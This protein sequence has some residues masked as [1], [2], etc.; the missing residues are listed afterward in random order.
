MEKQALRQFLRNQSQAQIPVTL[1]AI[2][3][4]HQQIREKDKRRVGIIA[5]C[6]EL[7]PAN[8]ENNNCSSQVV[9]TIDLGN[10]NFQKYL[11]I[12]ESKL[13]T[14]RSSRTS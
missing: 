8:E 5:N 11:H 13:V 3:I 7:T 6:Y 12:S 4:K 10:Y 2:M 9:Q 14:V 1:Y